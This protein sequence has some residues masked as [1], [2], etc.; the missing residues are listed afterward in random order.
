MHAESYQM[1]L[2][3]QAS[4]WTDQIHSL[5]RLNQQD[6]GEYLR[7]GETMW[8]EEHIRENYR[9]STNKWW[10]PGL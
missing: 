4:E 6:R 7:L 5:K 9:N 3:F 10:G 8:Q 1:P 2:K